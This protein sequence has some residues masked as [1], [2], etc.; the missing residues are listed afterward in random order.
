MGYM[1]NAQ[2]KYPKPSSPNMTPPS[3]R[4]DAKHGSGI[5]RDG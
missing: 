1:S 5:L 2:H 4:K 3:A